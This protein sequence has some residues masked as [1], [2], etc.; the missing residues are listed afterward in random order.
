MDIGMRDLFSRQE[1]RGEIISLRNSLANHPGGLDLG[2]RE[3]SSRFTTPVAGDGF[4]RGC[5]RRFRQDLDVL[6]A[7][8][9][10]VTDTEATRELSFL[11]PAWVSVDDQETRTLEGILVKSKITHTDFPPKPWHTYYD[12]NFFVRPDQ[13]YTYLLAPQNVF[14]A[15]GVIECEWDTGAFP[16]IK[17]QSEGTSI[18]LWPQVGDRVWIVGRWIYDVGIPA[19]R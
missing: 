18:L 12:W 6:N 7:L 2:L 9:D 1:I 11:I 10:V 16:G 8:L 14:H 17:E 19:S 15:G 13:Q 4:R 3:A 5:H